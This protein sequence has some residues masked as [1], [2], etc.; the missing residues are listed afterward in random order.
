MDLETVEVHSRDLLIKWVQVPAGHTLSYQ[1]KPTKKSI[2][3]ALYRKPTT[4]SSSSDPASRAR[5]GGLGTGSPAI[6]G[7][8]TGQTCQ[9]RLSAA[10]LVEVVWGGRVSGGQVARGT[11]DVK[12]GE[13]GMYALV[14]DNTFSKQLSKTVTFI[15]THAPTPSPTTLFSASSL[16][17]S[18]PTLTP[19]PS[20]SGGTT[21][22]GPLLKR[23]RKALQGYA[24]RYFTLD[25]PT[26]TLSYTHSPSTPAHKRGIIPLPLATITF[27]VERREIVV[28]AGAEMWHLRCGGTF[29][30]ESWREAMEVAVEGFEVRERMGIAHSGAGTGA[31]SLKVRANEQQQQRERDD[32]S[33][34]KVEEL[35]NR[36]EGVKEGIKDVRSDINSATASP[37]LSAENLSPIP[38]PSKAPAKGLFKRTPSGR[39]G[40]P[41][42][43]PPPS[44]DRVLAP[45]VSCSTSSGTK[46]RGLEREVEDIIAQLRTVTASRAR[47]PRTPLSTSPLSPKFEHGFSRSPGSSRPSIDGSRSVMTT[48]NEEWFDA[49]DQHLATSA[50]D[51]VGHGSSII[52]LENERDSA[53]ALMD[54]QEETESEEEVFMS[55]GESYSTETEE[56]SAEPE[57]APPIG[58]TSG[59]TQIFRREDSRG[60]IATIRSTSTNTGDLEEGGDAGKGR[61]LYPLERVGEVRRRANLPKEV[62]VQPPSLLAF[63]RKNVGK[64]LSSIAMPVASNEPLNLLQRIAEELEYS[65]LLT[66]AQTKPKEDGERIL[67]IAAFAC[68]AFSNM[69]AKERSVRKVFNPLLG[70]TFECVREDRGWRFIAEKVEHRPPIVAMCVES[71]HGWKLDASPSPEQ[72]FWGKSAEIITHGSTHLELGG[73][74]YVWDKPATFLRNIAMGEKYVEPT[75]TMTV[76]NQTTGEKAVVTFKAG[77]MFSGRS[78][79]VA[80]QAFDAGEK[81]QKLGLSGKWT[82]SL[83]FVG[84]GRDGEVVWSVD[85]LVDVPEKHCGFTQFAAQLNE[86]TEIERGCLPITDTRLRPDQRMCEMGEL[87]AAE[88]IKLA[89]EE[90]QRSRRKEMEANGETW[91][92]RWFEKVSGEGLNAV[93]RIKDGEDGYWREREKGDWTGVMHIFKH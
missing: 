56:S 87:D 43:Y 44:P 33:W 35:V 23:R 21:H 18:A 86:V 57:P 51:A 49:E 38:S 25:I 1:I 20:W 6:P 41:T 81:V 69:R 77:K 68:S 80:V 65:R 46:L 64:D 19:D 52:V 22:S 17:T 9:Q 72:K 14:F 78:E 85:P 27:V 2:N 12:N 75:G 10:G 24:R 83:A 4:P 63:L 60:T 91:I 89:L 11:W 48:T 58:A 40:T 92:P 54:V 42:I 30:F 8:Q 66:V 61:V 73:D 32:E 26:A 90:N 3:Y 62:T 15:I 13:A 50:S 36:L 34:M 88:P 29:E 82:Q 16:N 76:T 84:G 53:T 71:K 47:I 37:N 7:P 93:W 31:G 79:D 39:T 28:D 70:E 74:V 59:A 55:D 67:W 5:G 45:L